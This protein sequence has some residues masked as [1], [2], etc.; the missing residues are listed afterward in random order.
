MMWPTSTSSG[1]CLGRG[2]T[3]SSENKKATVLKCVSM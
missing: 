2:I 3:S 1:V